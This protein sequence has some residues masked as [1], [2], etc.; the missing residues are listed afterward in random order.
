M[1]TYRLIGLAL[2][3]LTTMIGLTVMASL[4]IASDDH[5]PV[6]A[7]PPVLRASEPA[8]SVVFRLPGPPAPSPLLQ[9]IRVAA[10]VPVP[11]PLPNGLVLAGL[12][13]L[14]AILI[15][16]KPAAA[17]ET[18][19]MEREVAFFCQ[20]QIG[21]WK[22]TDARKTLGAPLRTRVALDENK[23]ANGKIYAFRDPTGRYREL[24]LDF[25][26][27]TGALRTVFGYPPQLTWPEAHHRW[28]GEVTSADAQQGRKFYSYAN[29]RMDVLVDSQGKVISLGLY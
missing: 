10:P 29:R 12:P 2:S 21:Q 19:S 26:G 16:P 3:G 24:E 9:K 25:D 23:V 8:D 7:V 15:A 20:K 27:P 11:S 6:L 4:A 28:S 5:N 13:P 1:K 22:E 18:G 17:P 14:P